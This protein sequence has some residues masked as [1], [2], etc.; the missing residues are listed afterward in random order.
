MLL[1]YFLIILLLTPK[2]FC[3]RC[4]CTSGSGENQILPVILNNNNN[5]NNI[6]NPT[7]QSCSICLV[8]DLVAEHR[9]NCCNHRFHKE[10]I[11]SWFLKG[12]LTCPLCCRVVE[13]SLMDATCLESKQ[14][15]MTCL[16]RKSLSTED[17][18]AACL[19]SIAIDNYD[20][21]S[22]IYRMLPFQYQLD[23]CF[24]ISKTSK[25]SPDFFRPFHWFYYSIRD[26]MGNTVFHWAARSHNYL[27]FQMVLS[28]IAM[29]NEINAAG[30]TALD[31][32]GLDCKECRNCSDGTFKEELIRLGFRHSS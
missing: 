19:K 8:D 2:T 24:A 3:W 11:M 23:C 15:V 5:N 6:V 1:F 18:F 13:V 21:F 9:L 20:I 7:T 30:Q 12:K 25:P 32:E 14:L 4:C 22:T 10:C 31:V 16:R 27:L 28:D 26:D 29:I 17:A